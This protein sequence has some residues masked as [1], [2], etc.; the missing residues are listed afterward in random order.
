V[1]AAMRNGWTEK[2]LE[3]YENSSQLIASRLESLEAGRPGGYQKKFIAQS[4]AN[5]AGRVDKI[6]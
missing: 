5:K 4:T 3:V 2:K 6:I 1:I